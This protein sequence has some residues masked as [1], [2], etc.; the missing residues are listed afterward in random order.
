LTAEH[1]YHL[2]DKK[3]NLLPSSQILVLQDKSLNLNMA[4]MIEQLDALIADTLSAWN[5]YTTLIALAL[6]A[7]VAYPLIFW[8]EPDTHPLLLARQ[9][10]ASPVRQPRE[11]AV[12]RSTEVPHGYALKTGLSVRAPGA[13]KWT[14]G[15]D[16][17]LRDVWREAVN[18]SS[19]NAKILSVRGN[20]SPVEHDLSRLSKTINIIG[21]HLQKAGLQ[22]V[23]IYMPNSIDY[24]L[25]I[26]ACSFYGLT[27]ILVPFNQ[28]HA[29]VCTLLEKT[30]AQAVIATAGSL[31][32]A[33]LTES[34]SSLRHVVWVT[35]PANKHMDWQGAPD[36]ETRGK[37]EV[38]VWDHLVTEASSTNS[39]LPK[40]DESV[41]PGNLIF[42]WQTSTNSPAEVIE[43]TQKNMVAAIAALMSALPQR[44]RLGP[45]DL[46]LP[47]DSFSHSYV[48]CLTMAAL[49]SHSSLIINSVAG[50]GVDLSL[51]IRGSPTVVIASS[52]S[53]A[54]VHQTYVSGASSGLHK[55]VHSNHQRALAA[56]RMPG[57]D[58]LYKIAAPKGN[59]IGTSAGKLRLI[60]A[61]ER[62]GTGGAALSSAALRDLRIITRSRICYALTAPSVAGAVAQ[63]NIYDY[64]HDD[65]PGHSHF[66][67][68]LSSVEIKL[69]DKDDSKV[70]GSTPSGEIV[71]SGPAVVGGES[72]LGVRGVFREDCTLGYA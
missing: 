48:L 49:F 26:F 19:A 20:D 63:T 5:L 17:D 32:L 31:P 45:S 46:V 6:F 14:A 30:Q 68:P 53:L 11:S 1:P 50:T 39:E 29:T 61:S 64:R 25:A 15:K 3:T 24:L 7:F 8:A 10:A 12:Y 67:A 36:N 34:V 70:D 28:D 51:A 16:G 23:A 54:N 21:S 57:E 37:L 27:P 41:V 62:A 52:Q 59:A 2:K 47:A 44:Q 9:A 71:V 55:F 66:G 18:S 22:R 65:R 13:P 42:L 4:N 43:F 60:F 72:N 58:L 40:S 33:G 69:V 35:D 56:G 38:N